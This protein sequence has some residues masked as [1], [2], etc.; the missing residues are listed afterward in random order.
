MG[1]GLFRRL[2]YRLRQSRH[3]AELREEL[4]AHRAMRQAR[5]ER[6]G[7]GAD[8]A[9]AQSPCYGQCDAGA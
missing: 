8:E 7:L 4:E 9:A 3:D 5:L 2:W 1:V 6:D